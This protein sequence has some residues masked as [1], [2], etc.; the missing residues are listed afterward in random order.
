MYFVFI[1]YHQ[2]LTVVCKAFSQ[3]KEKSLQDVLQRL[4]FLVFMFCGPA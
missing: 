3:I 4:D 1:D 2:F